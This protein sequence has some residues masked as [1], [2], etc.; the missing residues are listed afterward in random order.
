MRIKLNPILMLVMIA[1]VVLAISILSIYQVAPS[2]Q[3]QQPAKEDPL[4]KTKITSRVKKAK[5]RGEQELVY[6]HRKL[7]MQV[8][9]VVRKR[10]FRNIAPS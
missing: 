3:R 10:F 5:E 6:M 7:I 1:S 4:E 2:G 8:A 9:L